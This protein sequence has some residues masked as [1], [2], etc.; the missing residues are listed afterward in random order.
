MFYFSV[1]TLSVARRLTGGSPQG[2]TRRTEKNAA[3]IFSLV[4]PM[5]SVL[6]KGMPEYWLKALKTVPPSGGAKPIGIQVFVLR[7]WG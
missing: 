3:N 6:L 1:H 7:L 4:Q 5:G 2:Y